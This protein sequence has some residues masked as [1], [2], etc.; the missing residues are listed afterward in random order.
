MIDQ[1]KELKCKKIR[2][3]EYANVNG[4]KYDGS[5]AVKLRLSRS[6]DVDVTWRHA[7]SIHAGRTMGMLRVKAARYLSP[8]A[9]RA[10]RCVTGRCER[11]RESK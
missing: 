6:R 10:T 3:L 1:K 2:N 11:D 7:S 4:T 9:I 8:S 5:E